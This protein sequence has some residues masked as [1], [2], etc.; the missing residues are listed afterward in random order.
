MAYNNNAEAYAEKFMD[1]EPYAK[2]AAEF[3]K[4]LP[5]GASVLDVGCGPGNLAKQLSVAAKS[6]IITG[7]DLSTE[8]IE[9]ARK[10][11][12]SGKF[13]TQDSRNARFCNAHYNAVVLSFS[14]VHL[15]D[16]EAYQLL[17]NAVNWLIPEG[18]MY[19]SFMEGKQA[20]FE[21][22]SFSKNPIYYN[23]F[24]GNEIEQFL[25][26]NGIAIFRTVRQDYVEPDGSITTDIFIF[27]K[28]G[29]CR[30]ARKLTLA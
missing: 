27:G 18:L 5:V 22:T 25:I 4:L 13:Y 15:C 30:F 9:K 2:H 16:T 14:I 28:K 1:Y 7:I 3:A 19:L 23:Y 17:A 21:E 8:M 12:P 20:G 10:N 29:K 26:A 11:V 24:D 6:I